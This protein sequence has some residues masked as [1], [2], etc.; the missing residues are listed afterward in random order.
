MCI[1]LYFLTVLQ[2]K[3]IKTQTSFL[4][5]Q[6]DGQ[7]LRCE[8]LDSIGVQKAIYWE[9]FFQVKNTAFPQWQYVTEYCN[10]CNV[11]N[12]TVAICNK[13]IF[14]KSWFIRN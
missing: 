14:N 12:S 6:I 7:V 5:T 2:Y 9:S 13:G 1:L 4:E 11:C 10:V 3:V 8:I